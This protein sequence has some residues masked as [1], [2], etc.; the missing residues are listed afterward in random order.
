MENVLKKVKLRQVDWMPRVKP[1]DFKDLGLTPEH[2]S[3]QEIHHL[4]VFIY[5]LTKPNSNITI[6][7]VYI[8]QTVDFII[9][10]VNMFR[11]T[12]FDWTHTSTFVIWQLNHVVADPSRQLH[13]GN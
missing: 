10:K 3:L 4:L 8:Y 7:N 11:L 1:N 6:Y 5:P 2:R 9:L 13:V 12:R